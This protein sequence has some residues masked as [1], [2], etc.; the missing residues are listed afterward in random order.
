MGKTYPRRLL[1]AALQILR[2]VE[3]ASSWRRLR[4][5]RGHALRLAK[6]SAHCTSGVHTA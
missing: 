5:E 6:K 1:R 4:V 2:A 3:F